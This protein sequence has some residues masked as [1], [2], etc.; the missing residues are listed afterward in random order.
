MLTIIKSASAGDRLRVEL[1][2]KSQVQFVR[3]EVAVL[4]AHSSMGLINLP[5]MLHKNNIILASSVRTT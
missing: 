1:I 5:K 3:V 4:T 2:S